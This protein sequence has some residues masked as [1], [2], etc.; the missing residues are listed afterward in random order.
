M[1]AFAAMRHGI[2]L[3]GMHCAEFKDLEWFPISA[4]PEAFVDH[5]AGG[6]APD[7]QGDHQE[8]WRE[9]GQG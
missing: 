8:N 4:K 7:A 3:L 9:D 6:I 5:R 1:T 2:Y